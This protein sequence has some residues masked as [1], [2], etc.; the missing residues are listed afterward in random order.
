MALGIA[1][2]QV[3][4]IGPSALHSNLGNGN[5]SLTTITLDGSY[6]AG[7]IPLTPTQLGLNDSVLFGVVALRTPSGTG[8]AVA[9]V[10]D[11][12]T[13]GAPKLKL[14]TATGEVAAASNSGAIVDVLAFG[15]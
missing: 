12:T 9:G 4:P 6:V 8:T 14:N 13:P 2:K 15:Y 3:D 7:G 1:P 11:C 10:L 5:V